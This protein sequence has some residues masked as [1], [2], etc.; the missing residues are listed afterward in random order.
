[1]K[2][3]RHTMTA[4]AQKQ[5]V[6]TAVTQPTSRSFLRRPSDSMGNRRSMANSRPP[7]ST[8]PAAANTDTTARNRLDTLQ[9]G[10]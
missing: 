8:N 6:H 5:V 7:Y 4:L 9:Q 10:H 1:M 3:Q 2:V